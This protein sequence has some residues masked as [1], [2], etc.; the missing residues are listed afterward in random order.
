MHQTCYFF[1]IAYFK[2]KNLNLFLKKWLGF[3]KTYLQVQATLNNQQTKQSFNEKRKNIAH[4]QRA[5]QKKV[6]SRSIYVL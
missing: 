5:D 3:E 4:E 6:I 1:K 2:Q